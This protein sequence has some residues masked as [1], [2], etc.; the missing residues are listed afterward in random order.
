VIQRLSAGHLLDSRRFAVPPDFSAPALADEYLREFAPLSEQRSEPYLRYEVFTPRYLIIRDLDTFDL[1]ENRQLGPR[2]AARVSYGLPGLGADFSALGLAVAASWAASPAG[3]YTLVS[4]TASTRLR[5]G[6]FIDETSTEQIY[7]A[8]PM[9]RRVVRL[10][11]AGGASAARADTQN[12]RYFLGGDTG[13]RGY[14]INAIDGTSMLVG[15]VELRSQAVHIYS[16]RVGGLLFY[17][18]GGAAPSFGSLRAYHDF[19]LGLRWLIPQLNSAVLRLDWAIAEPAAPLTRAGLPGRIT[20]GF[21][22][23]F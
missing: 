10:V 16:Q 11:V 13:L 4:V 5:D 23:V 6:R 19:G 20:G 14:A 8:T 15:H 3:G 12:T 7:L 22:Q 21:E 1:R 18:V 2:F 9:F 17:D